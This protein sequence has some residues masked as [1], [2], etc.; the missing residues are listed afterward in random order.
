M[1]LSD[2]T[3]VLISFPTFTSR[4]YDPWLYMHIF[5]RACG[6]WATGTPSFRL[7]E[8]VSQPECVRAIGL[9]ELVEPQSVEATY[10]VRPYRCTG[11]LVDNVSDALTAGPAGAVAS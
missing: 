1:C 6:T 4:I 8:I 11:I 5:K 2:I 9:E 10:I 7:L 3:A